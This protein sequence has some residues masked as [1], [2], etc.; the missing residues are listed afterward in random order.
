MAVVVP[1]NAIAPAS[2]R[3]FFLQVIPSPSSDVDVETNAQ[4]SP[5]LHAFV[6]ALMQVAWQ[7]SSNE[8]TSPLRQPSAV[9]VRHC[10][11]SAISQAPTLRV[12][13]FFSSESGRNVAEMTG[14][15]SPVAEL[16]DSPSVMVPR[17]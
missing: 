16:R 7:S 9:P 17:A 2:K 5:A 14:D 4:T 8:Q 6:Q 10:G 13:D 1:L 3:S 11:I 12:Q 15:E